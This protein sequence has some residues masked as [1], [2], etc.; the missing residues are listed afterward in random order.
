[1][2]PIN[3]KVILMST[4]TGTMPAL[5]LPHGGGP[6]FFMTG[7]MAELF[8]PMGTFL[9]GIEDV[10]PSQPTAI[11]VVTAHWETE[12][13][14]VT[15]G[16][17]PPLIFDYYGFPEETYAL[18]YPAPGSP[19]LANE[20]VALLHGEQIE[21][22]VNPTIGWDHGVFIPLKMMF[23]EATI[24]VVSVSL[25][26]DLD[27]A[28][29]AL[30]G[31]ALRP[32]RDQGVLIIGSGMSYHNLAMLDGAVPSAEFHRWLDTA[33]AGDLDSREQHLN[34]WAGAPSGRASHPREEHL[35]PLMVVSAAGSDAPAQK[36]WNGHMGPTQVD[37]WAFH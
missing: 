14:A 13:V 34:G 2:T 24:P 29:H 22:S 31:R 10:L 33:L 4:S 32:L 15:G 17:R 18:T 25:T 12:H 36:I 23:P 9:Q 16:E 19:T 21:A 5:Y 37:A 8:A 11:V 3:R 30:V 20:I 28:R 35:M 1:M 7:P 6:A 26:A 27:P